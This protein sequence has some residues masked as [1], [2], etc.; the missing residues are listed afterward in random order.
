MYLLLAAGRRDVYGHQ[1]IKKKDKIEDCTQHRITSQH[2]N[3]IL[4][5]PTQSKELVIRK[6]DSI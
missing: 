3:P 1:K 5:C 6:K 2:I 4:L